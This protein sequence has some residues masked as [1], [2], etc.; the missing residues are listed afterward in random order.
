MVNHSA[1]NP[2]PTLE[3]GPAQRVRMTL[4]FSLLVHAIIVLGVGFSYEDPAARLPSL[5]V[6]LLT[7]S[8]NE[9]SKDP[10]F[11]ANVSQRGGGEAS[12]KRRPSSP[13]SGMVPK[14]DPGIAPVAQRASAPAPQPKRP[15]PILKTER[16]AERRIPDATRQPQVPQLRPSGRELVERSLEMARLAAEVNRQSETIARRPKRKYISANTQEYAEAAY[17]RAWVAR[18]ERIGNLNY[19]DEARH[20][21]MA[22]DLILTVAVRRDGSVESIDIIQSSGFTVLDEAAL[23]IVRLAE[24]FAPLPDTDEH[25]DIMHITRTWQFLPEGVLRNE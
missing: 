16:P 21:R 14:P 20:K 12:D 10:D 15:E 23:R 5:D 8:S 2:H 1:A 11:L 22:G 3:I 6:I 25:V 19:P 17:M 7:S 13:V 18:I 24:P 9:K 4:M